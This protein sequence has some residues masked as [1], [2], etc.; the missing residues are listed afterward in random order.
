MLIQFPRRR[1]PIIDQDLVE[2]RSNTLVQKREIIFPRNWDHGWILFHFLIKYEIL[3]LPE[4][5]ESLSDIK[6]QAVRQVPTHFR[7]ISS[8]LSTFYA[9]EQHYSARHSRCRE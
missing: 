6:F 4:Q 7:W 2:Y 9:N 3:S 8:E 1:L 5:T